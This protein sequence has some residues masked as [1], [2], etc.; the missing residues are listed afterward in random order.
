M[1]VSCKRE[2]DRLAETAVAAATAR[3]AGMM[4]TQLVSFTRLNFHYK[5]IFAQTCSL[6]RHCI[7]SVTMRQED[8]LLLCDRGTH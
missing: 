5:E 4:K 3:E 8:T 2:E 7:T 6:V 1:A